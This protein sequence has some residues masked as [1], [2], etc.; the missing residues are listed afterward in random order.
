MY[1]TNLSATLPTLCRYT[2]HSPPVRS[3]IVTGVDESR[4]EID[5]APINF[6]QNKTPVYFEENARRVFVVIIGGV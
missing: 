4:A 6:I 3:V 2:I 1:F 5:V